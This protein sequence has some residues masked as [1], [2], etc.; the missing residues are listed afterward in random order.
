[1][2]SAWW[3]RALLACW[4]ALSS[5]VPEDAL[6]SSI[7]AKLGALEEEAAWSVGE[8]E[9]AAE[10]L[11]PW[12]S[13]PPLL[14]LL[15]VLLLLLLVLLLLVLLLLLLLLLQVLLLLQGIDSGEDKEQLDACLNLLSGAEAAAC[16]GKALELSPKWLEEEVDRLMLRSIPL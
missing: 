10:A 11:T 5:V 8:E 9:V 13:A 14:L 6:V 2:G 3:A 12:F 7:S 15:L 4:E 16:A 1:M